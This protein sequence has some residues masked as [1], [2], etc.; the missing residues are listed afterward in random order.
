MPHQGSAGC[1]EV[2]EAGQAGGLS[3]QVVCAWGSPVGQPELVDY[4]P[5]EGHR[6]GDHG[7]VFLAQE[8]EVALFAA[9]FRDGEILGEWFAA[10]HEL[11]AGGGIDAI[12][13]RFQDGVVAA[14]DEGGGRGFGGGRQLVARSGIV[15]ARGGDQPVDGL[16]AGG[17]GDAE[18]GAGGGHLVLLGGRDDVILAGLLAW[19]ELLVST[20]SALVHDVEEA[21]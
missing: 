9:D 1:W 16:V 2:S 15:E 10:G 20:A 18:G 6:G 4:R 13:A 11:G 17:S 3:Y 5:G 14:G 19:E 21:I 7:G 12:A 8:E